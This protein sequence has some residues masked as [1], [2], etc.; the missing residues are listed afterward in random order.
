MGPLTFFPQEARVY[1]ENVNQLFH[2]VVWPSFGAF[3]RVFRFFAQTSDVSSNY[4]L[5]LAWYAMFTTIQKEENALRLFV[6]G[7]KKYYKARAQTLSRGQHWP[8][9][10]RFHANGRNILALR[11]AGHRTIEMLGLVG[12][13][14]WPVSNN[15]CQQ[16]PT[17]ANIVVATCKRRQQVAINW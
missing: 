16:V 11:F 2:L 10:L 17:S 8:T 9:L 6:F 1:L 7:K 13:K 3:T 5:N 12:P 15:K 4:S 14:V